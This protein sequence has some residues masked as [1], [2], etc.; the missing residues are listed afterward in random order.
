MKKI[1]RAEKASVPQEYR[2]EES[3]SITP[4]HPRWLEFIDRLAG[5][6]G[7]NFHLG[8]PF[9]ARSFEWTCDCSEDCP[10]SRRILSEMGFT[11][12]QVADSISHFHELGG[13][14]DC[15]VVFNVDPMDEES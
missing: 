4:D 12:H 1:V 8:V 13:W 6:G 15:E 3:N 5:A 14:C 9:D 2:S 11:N 10:L 7:C